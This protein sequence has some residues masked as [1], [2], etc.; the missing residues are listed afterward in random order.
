MIYHGGEPIS[1]SKSNKA[2]TTERNLVDERALH[3]CHGNAIRIGF[4]S[5]GGIHR[6]RIVLLRLPV[7]LLPDCMHLGGIPIPELRRLT[8]I[9]AHSA[10]TG[11]VFSDHFL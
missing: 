4:G 8:V 5:M 3:F 11:A 6:H 2:S 10:P 1:I 9:S 7:Q